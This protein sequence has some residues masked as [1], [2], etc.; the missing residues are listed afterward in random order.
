M[1]TNEQYVASGGSDDDQ[2][3]NADPA[4]NQTG[5]GTTVGSST[6]T[7]TVPPDSK[8]PGTSSQP[9]PSSAKGQSQESAPGKRLKNPLG[10]FASYTYQITLY[11]IT[12][13]AYDAFV[14]TGRRKIAVLTNVDNSGSGA[15][16]ICQSG[17]IPN[18]N[19][20]PGFKYDYYIDNLKIYNYISGKSTGTASGITDITFNITEP[21]G[22]SFIKNL[23]TAGDAIKKYST[24]LGSSSAQNPSR[25]FFVLG[26][27]FYGYDQNGNLLTGKEIKDDTVLDPQS[28]GSALFERFYDIVITDIKFKID[29]KAVIYNIASRC[30]GSQLAYGA[31]RGIINQT[32]PIEA[33]TVEEAL[34]GPKGLLTLLNRNQENLKQ[35]GAIKEK[36]NWSV[37][38]K[39][40]G[41][42][43]IRGASIVL[44]SDLSKFKFPGSQA[45]TSTEA[46]DALSVK[47]IP[48]SQKRNMII[49]GG[50]PILQAISRIISQS[51]YLEN[52][53]KI[54]YKSNVQPDPNKKA[55]DVTKPGS[56]ENISWYNLSAEISNARWDDL[57]GDWAYNIK[58]I[59]TPYDTPV[60][61]SPF[62][63]GLTSYY[64]P[65]KRY[66][67]WYTGKNTEIISYEQ[68]LDNLYYNAILLPAGGQ[69]SATDVGNINAAGI[70][71]GG[72]VDVPSSPSQRTPMQRLGKLNIGMEAQNSYLTDLYDPNAYAEA[73]IRIL[74][75][76]DFLM[77]EGTTSV[78]SLYNRFY[79]TD[80]FTINGNGGY[81]FVEVDFKEAVDYNH[82]TGVMDIN[83]SIQF[84]RYPQYIADK[85]K[86][87]SYLVREVESVFNN[88]GFTQTLYCNINTFGDLSSAEANL[89]RE[90]ESQAGSGTGSNPNDTTG[91]TGLTKDPKP[92]ES[93]GAAG[94]A[95]PNQNQNVGSATTT[96]TS[97]QPVKDDDNTQ[98]NANVPIPTGG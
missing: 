71:Q 25:Q 29:G 24:S 85:V 44:E 84:W 66:D 55:N 70:G 68:Q 26:I 12:P 43:A 86:G 82:S 93:Q 92:T 28:D 2:K 51:S 18:D 30:I 89:A 21:Y 8:T 78:N 48:N 15:Y 56:K 94:Q 95:E 47:A 9:S 81:V 19:R 75:D 7:S 50:T 59:I 52:A 46:T 91:S 54:I 34:T 88:G 31:K 96:P 79:G 20:A 4:K 69:L 60:T 45:K 53:L 72:P 35:Q 64:G 27:R 90:T 17:G 39:G 83:D 22:F 74:G 58:Y 14:Q 40:T 32:A 11:M 62:A 1:A 41:V 67:Y 5:S 63:N 49:N 76:P 36:N 77:Q 97:T 73:K 42:E 57:V 38:W 87:V 16:I 37:D 98:P 23:K 13:D 10:N 3:T 80:T 33:A 6:T 65:Y 61:I